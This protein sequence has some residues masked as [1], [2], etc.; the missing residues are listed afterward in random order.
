MERDATV[1]QLTAQLVSTPRVDV[2]VIATLGQLC[3]ARGDDLVSRRIVMPL[4]LASRGD[5]YAVQ[6]WVSP[7]VCVDVG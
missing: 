5:W 6:S 3:T 2:G 1:A 7:R 4:W